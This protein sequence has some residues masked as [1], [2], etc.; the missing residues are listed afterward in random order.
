MSLCCKTKCF[1]GTTEALNV[2]LRCPHN[3]HWVKL[4]RT[5]ILFLTLLW[6]L[7][8]KMI[9]NKSKKTTLPWTNGQ[10][11]LSCA[12]IS[13]FHDV[14]LGP[15]HLGQFFCLC[16]Q[17]TL[18]TWNLCCLTICPV[19][20]HGDKKFL[21]KTRAFKFCN[22]ET[23]FHGKCVFEFLS[24]VVRAMCWRT[25]KWSLKVCLIFS[26]KLIKFPRKRWKYFS[27]EVYQ[28]GQCDKESLA[29]R[30][31]EIERSHGRNSQLAP[32][33]GATQWMDGW[34]G[35]YTDRRQ[36]RNTHLNLL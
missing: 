21:L 28:L 33:G 9:G 12:S 14:F 23:G 24:K 4:Y 2:L 5:A 15:A 26:Q 1:S 22:S 25:T 27:I 32:A 29:G 10:T 11:V 19:V 6:F 8:H 3:A 30:Q 17:F 13:C 18:V 35:R 36:T 16:Y 20:E 7:I 34:T 31:E